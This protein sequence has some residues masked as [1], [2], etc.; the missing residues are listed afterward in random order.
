MN[1]R[2]Y[3]IQCQYIR[4]QYPLPFSGHVELDSLQIRC[5]LESGYRDI[6]ILH[7]KMTA[8]D[9]VTEDKIRPGE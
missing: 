6:F 5:S 7:A 9:T 1:E 8:V 4:Y 3:G 2:E